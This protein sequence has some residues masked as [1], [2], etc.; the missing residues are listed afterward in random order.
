MEVRYVS[1][2]FWAMFSGDIPEMALKQGLI[3]GR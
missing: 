2:R 3:Y 1:T